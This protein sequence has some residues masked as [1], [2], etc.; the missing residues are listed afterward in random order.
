MKTFLTKLKSFKNLLVLWAVFIITYIVIKGKQEFL[1]VAMLLAGAV[2][3]YFPVNVKQ[4]EILSNSNKDK[5]KN[6]DKGD[7][8]DN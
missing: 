8:H 2:I 3:V 7:K 5:D 1:S 6:Q 4:K